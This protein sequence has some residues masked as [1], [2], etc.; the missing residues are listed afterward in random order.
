MITAYSHTFD[1]IVNRILIDCSIGIPHVTNVERPMKALWDTG[2]CC[3]CIA[4]SVA[5]EMGLI[6]VNER[7]LI[8]ADNKPFMADVFCVRLKMGHFE[9]G[10]IEVCG[11]PMS[12]KMENMII[13]MD[14]ITKGDL[15]ITNYEGKTVLTFRE[16]SLEKIDYVEEL[17]LQKKCKDYQNVMARKNINTA[18]CACGSGKSYK[19][20]HGQ[21][22]YAKH[23]DN[24]NNKAIKP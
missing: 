11:I 21:T 14:V 9:I 2:A 5:H 16:P 8:G 20:C 19:N 3:T 18:K 7:E 23:E 6:K 1:V 10:N 24:L 17:K 13:G 12:G 22:V 15:S 4:T